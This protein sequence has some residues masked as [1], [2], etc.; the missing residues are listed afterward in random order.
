MVVLDILLLVVFVYLAISVVYVFG[1]SLAGRL[2]KLE[3]VPVTGMYR[4]FVVLIPSYK[5]DGVILE[6]ARQALLQDYPKEKYDVVVI[7]D[8]LKEETV[9]SLKA[10]PIKVVEVSF[11][12]STKAKSLNKAL[13]TLTGHYDYALILDADNIMAKDFVRKINASFVKTG[14][15]IVQGHRVAKNINTNF[16]ILDAISEEVNNHIFRKAHRVVGLSSALI[17]SGMAFE[18][19][20][21]KEI[22]ATCQ[23]VG[24]FDRE[25][26]L[27][28]LR[29]G[30]KM[31]YVEDA[32]VYDEKVENAEVFQNQRR[33]WMSAQLHYFSKYFFDGVWQLITKGNIDY[34][35]KVYQQFMLPRVLMLGSLLGITMLVIALQFTFSITMIANANL[36]MMLVFL[37][38]AGM[39]MAVPDSYYNKKTLQAAISLPKAIGVMFLTV[40]KLKGAN[41]KFIH[42]PHSGSLNHTLGADKK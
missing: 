2:G 37:Y 40:F 25:L 1:F 13:E 19:Q 8:S 20:Y 30:V 16:A 3:E 29:A 42:T 33:R 17:G 5:E 34:F 23:A 12:K 9:N 24:G 26:E 7:A 18:F 31:D 41:K 6:S 36:W 22:M 35:D 38:F 14:G 32:L 10:M 21:F 4:K 27:K 15:T 11:E 28:S 39:M